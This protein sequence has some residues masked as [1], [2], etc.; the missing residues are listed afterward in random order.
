MADVQE[1][2]T[3]GILAH[4]SALLGI[5]GMGL[6]AIIGP[7]IIYLIAKDK[8]EH[9]R[10]NAKHALNFQFSM[11]ILFAI[12][13]VVALLVPV[14]VIGIILLAVFDFIMVIIA[15]IKASQ[16]K[17]YSYPLEIKILK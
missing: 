1:D 13:L 6:G 17:I 14:L 10:E 15:A 8:S 9:A 3:W 12:M 16:G 5:V 2:K 11:L 4:A 7:L